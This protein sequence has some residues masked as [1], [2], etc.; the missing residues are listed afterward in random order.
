M[1]RK[2]FRK[3]SFVGKVVAAALSATLAFGMTPAMAFAQPAE[4]PA[5]S[6]LTALD[7]S[8]VTVLAPVNNTGMFKVMAAQLEGTKLRFTLSGV[9]YSQF[10]VG[11]Y[12]EAVA[13]GDG[14]TNGTWVLA[15]PAVTLSAGATEFVMDAPQAG[16]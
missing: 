11:T 10:Y 8:E 13:N 7:A 4:A 3:N 12:E 5:N 9:G 16:E 1:K 14:S 2:V 6:A 15:E